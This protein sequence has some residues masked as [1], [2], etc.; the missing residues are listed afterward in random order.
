MSARHHDALKIVTVTNVYEMREGKQKEIDIN[1]KE[2]NR[3]DR[4]VR[5]MR[6]LECRENGGRTANTERNKI[7]KNYVPVIRGSVPTL[8]L[9]PAHPAA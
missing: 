1:Q 5:S 9:A 7:V 3:A 6:K 2:E 8:R 4:R